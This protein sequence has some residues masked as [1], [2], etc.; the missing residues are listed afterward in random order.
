MNC[1]KNE[2]RFQPNKSPLKLIS[3]ERKCIHTHA[4]FARHSHLHFHCERVKWR[5]SSRGQNNNLDPVGLKVTHGVAWTE[6]PVA[7]DA[8]LWGSDT[9][10]AL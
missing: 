1:L 5:E 2:N 3:E 10:C 8:F 9:L 6:A 7:Q 4:H